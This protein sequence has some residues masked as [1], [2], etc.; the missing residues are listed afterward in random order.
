MLN[1]ERFEVNPFQENTYCLY[2]DK[3]EA[4]II[5]PG[6]YSKEEKDSFKKFIN[7]QQLHLQ[8]CWLTHAHLDHVFGCRFIYEEFGLSPQLHEKERMVY[9]TAEQVG[10]NYGIRLESLPEPIYSWSEDQGNEHVLGTAFNWYFTP[11][12]SPG[13]VSFYAE[14]SET[15]WSGDVLF[16]HSIGRTDLPGGNFETLEKSIRTVLY[17]LPHATRVLSGHGPET[18]IAFERD[19]NPFVQM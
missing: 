10:L 6:F 9:E 16:Y 5:D 2:N 12:H 4:L 3:K 14:A 15:V 13:S 7:E 17:R 1:V 18:N 11:G 19:S 8:H